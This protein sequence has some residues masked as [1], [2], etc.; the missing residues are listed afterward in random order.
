VPIHLESILFAGLQF[1]TG[2]RT[3]TG[4]VILTSGRWWKIKELPRVAG[5]VIHLLNW[6]SLVWR[7]ASP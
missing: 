5:E 2:R 6:I 4:E 3:G 7:T 1:A